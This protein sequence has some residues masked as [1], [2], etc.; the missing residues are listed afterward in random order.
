MFEYPS[1]L[2]LD[3]MPGLAEAPPLQRTTKTS[4][5]GSLS[6]SSARSRTLVK[7]DMSSLVNTDVSSPNVRDLANCDTST[8]SS[9]EKKRNKP[10]Y[11]RTL[12]ACGMLSSHALI[13]SL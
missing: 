2:S 13:F 5:D 11:H 6:L 7:D 4:M 8:M 9:A 10:G 3:L 12:A 1:V